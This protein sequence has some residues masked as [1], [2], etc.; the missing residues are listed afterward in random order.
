MR[1]EN[2]KFSNM[3]FYYDQ[4]L[5]AFD[6]FAYYTAE[7]VNSWQFPVKASEQMEL[8]DPLKSYLSY[9]MHQA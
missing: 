5:D 9:T 6:I 7:E 8:R 2:V 1:P 4:F 3:F